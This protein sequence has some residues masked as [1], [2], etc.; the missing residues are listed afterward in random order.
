LLGVCGREL[1]RD[2]KPVRPDESEVFALV[3]QFEI[4]VQRSARHAPIFAR[5]KD[6]EELARREVGVRKAPFGQLRRVIRQAPIIQ[7]ERA[8]TAV[9]NFDPI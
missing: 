8:G 2:R 4:R 3:S 9:M 7:V 1:R 5:S 6:H